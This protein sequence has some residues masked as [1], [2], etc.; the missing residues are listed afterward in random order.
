MASSGNVKSF[1]E[2]YKV[3]IAAG[4]TAW[5][6]LFFIHP[7]GIH[8]DAMSPTLKDGQIVIVSKHTYKAEPPSL[9]QIVDFNRDFSKD[10][11]PGENEVRRVVGIPGDTIEIKNGIVYRN[12]EPLREK[13][14]KVQ[15]G[16]AMESV[17]L[18]DGE[19]FVLG[20]S[21][22]NSIDSRQ[23]GALKMEKLRGEC[24]FILWPLASFGAVE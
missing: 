8:G 22:K 10:G 23:V 15:S 11:A 17:T 19:I 7:V 9:Y 1:K 2:K 6:I 14:A 24:S 12:G 3:Y 5:I 16:E 13:Y 21:P 20:D 4:I 18:D